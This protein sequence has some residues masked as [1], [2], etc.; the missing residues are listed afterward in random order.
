MI[1]TA[2]SIVL[3][4]VAGGATHAIAGGFLAAGGGPQVLGLMGGLSVAAAYDALVRRDLGG[5]D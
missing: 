3:A 1:R 4:L 5:E 2:L